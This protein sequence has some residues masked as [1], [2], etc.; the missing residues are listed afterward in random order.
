M[1]IVLE[2]PAKAA[3]TDRNT[4]LRLVDARFDPPL[5]VIAPGTKAVVENA[6]VVMHLIESTTT[7][8]LPMKGRSVAPGDR[9]T[10]VFAKA[11][12]YRLH[13]SEVPHMR[14]TVF[15]TDQPV[16]ALPRSDGSFTFEGIPA[17]RYLLRVWHDGEWIHSMGVRVRGRT[18]VDVEIPSDSEAE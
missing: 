4:T 6:D 7:S 2:G 12:V 15:V 9:F 1:A 14:A 16:V 3:P 10:H 18:S 8:P 5:L 13:C 17:E 11:G